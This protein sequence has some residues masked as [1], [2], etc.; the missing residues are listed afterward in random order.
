MIKIK[1]LNLV[2]LNNK[3]GTY[4]PEQNF[5]FKIRYLNLSQITKQLLN[6]WEKFQRL[7]EIF[8]NTAVKRRSLNYKPTFRLKLILLF[9]RVRHTFDDYITDSF[10]NGRRCICLVF[11]TRFVNYSTETQTQLCTSRVHNYLCNMGADSYKYK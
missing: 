11:E 9:S 8:C 6:V 10:G 3:L 7:V 5:E 1:Y 4:L 2:N